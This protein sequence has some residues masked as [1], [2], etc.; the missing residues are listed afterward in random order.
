[1]SGRIFLTAA[2]ASG[3]AIGA[4]L[5]L[6][7]HERR[8]DLVFG[9]VGGERMR[10][11]GVSSPIDLA[12]LQTVGLT[13]G[14]RV[15][16]RARHLARETALEAAAFMP[17]VVVP[18]D[19]WGF[20]LRV[21]QELRRMGVPGRIVKYIGPQVWASRPG[22]ARQL[23]PLIDGLLCVFQMEVPYYAPYGVPCTV[24][25]Y[26]A[27]ARETAGDKAGFRTRHGLEPNTPLLLVLFGSRPREVRRIAADF[28]AS[29]RA[30]RGNVP[31]LRVATVVAPE[32][33]AIVQDRQRDWGFDAIVCGPDEKFDAFAA[34]DVALCV[35]G[36]VTTEVALQGTPVLVGY[37]VDP[38]T[39]AVARAGVMTA[40]Y[41]TLM[42]ILAGQ[43]VAPEFEQFQLK[44][45]RIAPIASR[46]L[47]DPEVRARQVEA[48]FAALDLMGR[49][50][51]PAAERAA[52]ALLEYLPVPDTGS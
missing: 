34:A 35:S 21:I 32:V 24:V 48:Q 9:G 50:Q 37:R 8:P 38:L 6:A 28:E 18:I 52:D 15:I 22:R 31:G 23:A 5:I 3:D 42:N 26:P 11:L 10:A 17:D 12:G 14:L 1:M 40:R 2:E 16:K 13:D 44:A 19:A 49:G 33:A 29:V 7:L 36:T 30:L 41:F 39:W 47:L 20:S 27:V 45:S 25:G 46:L 51:P 4:D 43:E